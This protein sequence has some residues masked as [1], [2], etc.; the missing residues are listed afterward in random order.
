MKSL[1]KL[2]RKFQLKYGADGDEAFWR[3]FDE[4]ERIRTLDEQKTEQKTKQKEE[5]E[6]NIYKTEEE[7][8]A[9]LNNLTLP[10]SE[11]QI[12]EMHR[13]GEF[14]Q[15]T[16]DAIRNLNGREQMQKEFDQQ[17]KDIAEQQ[18]KQKAEQQA[19]K[20]SIDGKTPFNKDDAQRIVNE[21][22]PE[23]KKRAPDL[24]GIQILFKYSDRWDVI[25]TYTAERL[26][27]MG[28]KTLWRGYMSM[29]MPI[30]LSWRHYLIYNKKYLVRGDI[31]ITL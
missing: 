7:E 16:Y 27:R 28:N 4:A 25:I 14:C 2:A 3:E 8:W 6:R 30:M 12:N 17:D 1:L 10:L 22:I 20:K 18:A 21:F 19:Y 26:A 5:E 24:K 11:D 9:K 29:A 23:M 31:L 13:D 15:K